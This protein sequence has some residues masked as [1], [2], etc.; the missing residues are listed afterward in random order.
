MI[1]AKSNVLLSL[2]S[3]PRRSSYLKLNIYI[4]LHQSTTG[5]SA[6][7]QILYVWILSALVVLIIE[8]LLCM[9]F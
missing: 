2:S 5:P 6:H 7:T 9:F 1:H 8:I 3:L 4:Y